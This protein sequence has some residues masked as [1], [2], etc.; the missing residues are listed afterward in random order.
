MIHNPS[1]GLMGTSEDFRETAD[2]L[3]KMQD[4][5]ANTYVSAITKNGKLIDGNIDKTKKKVL[6]MMEAETWLSANEAL[7]F[8]FIDTVTEGA[9][10]V[11]KENALQMFNSCKPFKNT[12]AEFTNK[13]EKIINMSDQK[14]EDVDNK[15]F[16][17]KIVSFFKTNPAEAKTLI[18]KANAEAETVR[19]SKIAE[20]RQIAKDNGFLKE[21][22]I[23]P[24]TKA[25]ADVVEEPQKN[26]ELELLKQQIKA[27][28]E[29]VGAPSAG[30]DADTKLENK[31]L[32]FFPTELHKKQ[33]EA[34]FK[35][36]TKHGR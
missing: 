18:D 12:P 31:G 14:T 29:E 20:A 15:T 33:G 1:A 2:L 34:L 4:E 9:E 3:D 27:L 17:E 11:T 28:E 23:E 5:L 10:F 21:D 8:G 7:E 35:A 24:T 25:V 32:D 26:E 13:L 36:M 22:V 19:L 16:L 30:G 6:K